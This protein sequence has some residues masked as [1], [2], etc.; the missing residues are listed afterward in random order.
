VGS[1]ADVP[2][3]TTLGE[4][5]PSVTLLKNVTILSPN[6]TDSDT[7][8]VALA[9]PDHLTQDVTPGRPDPMIPDFADTLGQ[10]G[11]P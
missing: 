5:L 3:N 6:L 7:M 9:A 8:D 1:V 11:P 10:P 2:E 4:K